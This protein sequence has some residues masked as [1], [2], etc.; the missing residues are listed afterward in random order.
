[1]RCTTYEVETKRNANHF[2]GVLAAIIHTCVGLLRSRNDVYV[3][4]VTHE[5][6]ATFCLAHYLYP[7][8][9]V[10]ACVCVCVCESE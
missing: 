4:W 1:M 10:V 5:T 7:C 9:F 8:H 6:N 3:P 2:A